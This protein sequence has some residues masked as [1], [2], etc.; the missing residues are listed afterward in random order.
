MKD[1][2]PVVNRKNREFEKPDFKGYDIASA[3]PMAYPSTIREALRA[4]HEQAKHVRLH[5]QFINGTTT[6]QMLLEEAANN[7]AT[8]KI[9]LAE[10]LYFYEG[11]AIAETLG[12]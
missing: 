10:S 5:A 2:I 1:Y 11:I 4:N 3:L 9:Q 8:I 7:R 12:A 6:K